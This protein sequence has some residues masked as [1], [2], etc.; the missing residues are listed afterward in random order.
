MH[1]I[2]FFGIKGG[3]GRTTATMALA[4]GFLALGKRVAVMDCSD[5]AGTNLK[6]PYPCELQNWISAM[7]NCGFRAPQFEFLECRT[8]E[9]VEDGLA[10]AEGRWCMDLMKRI[11]PF[12]RQ[13]QRRSVTGLAALIMRFSTA[14]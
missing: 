12:R 10:R 2:T 14:T 4:S 8:G 1:T 5:P 13:A 7:A 6:S 3:V 9:Q 11:F